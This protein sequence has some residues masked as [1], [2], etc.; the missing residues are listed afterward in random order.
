MHDV[1]LKGG[2]QALHVA[3]VVVQRAAVKIRAGAQVAGAEV[4]QAAFLDQLDERIAQ[5]ALRARDAPIL[6]PLPC[7]RGLRMRAG[8]DR[9]GRRRCFTCFK[10]R[11]Q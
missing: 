11:E 3:E 8:P 7:V 6:D 5:R 10:Q 4:G 9:D 2:E 1:V